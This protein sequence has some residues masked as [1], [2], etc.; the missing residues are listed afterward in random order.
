MISMVQLEVVLNPMK[1]QVGFPGSY[2]HIK[3]SVTLLSPEYE[4]CGSRTLH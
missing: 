2:F 4:E 1:L 3:N